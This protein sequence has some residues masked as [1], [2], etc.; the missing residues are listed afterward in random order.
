VGQWLAA[1]GN[2]V[3]SCSA[4]K[5]RYRDQLRAHQP[6]VCFLHLSGP[7][8]LIAERLTARRGHFMATNLLQSQFDVLE[9][10]GTD[11]RGV[12]IDIIGR[13]AAAVVDGFLASAPSP[14]DGS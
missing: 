6:S 7:L 1:N 12:T 8:E 9:P 3:V 2:G 13:D 4:L 11:E 5:R 10:L 14:C